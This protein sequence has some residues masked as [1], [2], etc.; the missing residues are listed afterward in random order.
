MR[1]LATLVHEPEARTWNDGG[2]QWFTPG[3]PD[4][5]A[6]DQWTALTIAAVWACQTLIADAVASLPVDTFRK[7]AGL[8]EETTKPAWMET[9]NPENNRIDYE[10][11]RILSLLGWGNAYTFLLREGGSSDPMAP[12]VERWLLN[13]ASVLVQRVKNS[14]DET[15]QLQYW[16]RGEPVALGNMQHIRGYTPPGYFKG[17]SPITQ[18]RKGLAMMAAAEAAG[19][20]IYDQGMMQSGALEVPGMPAEVSKEVTA[21]LVETVMERHAGAG[22]AGKPMILT[23]GTKWSPTMMTMSDAQY[24]ETRRFE[25]DE[26]CRWYRVPPHKIQHIVAHA[27]QGGG[28]GIEQMDTEFSQDTLLS[29]VTRLEIADSLLIPRGQYVKYNINAY[30]RADMATRYEAY[31]KGRLA[32]FLNADDIRAHEDLPPLPDD[33]GQIFLQPANY[34]E[35]G[36]TPV[37]PVNGTPVQG[38]TDG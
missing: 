4:A 24:L 31:N 22:N 17:M 11:Q 3:G 28:M 12:V 38:A 35:A 1:G 29:W 13:P 6:V 15:A 19:A 26:V 32:G 20:N 25:I 36:T 21:R 34:I 23:G 27:S 37:V 2:S 8:R 18:A 30:V 9:P 33:K 7:K 10:T 14:Y 5:F 16:H